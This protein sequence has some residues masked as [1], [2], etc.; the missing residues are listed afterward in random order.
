MS[1]FDP[2]TLHCDGCTACCRGGRVTL[3]QSLGD[4]VTLYEVDTSGDVLKRKA[5][6]SC[7]YLGEQGCTIYERRPVVCRAFDCRSYATS[8]WVRSAAYDD[9]EI[10][11]AAAARMPEMMPDLQREDPA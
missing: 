11:A 2:A 9:R 1:A 10:R 3:H 5:D 4:D 8:P 7:H 6:G